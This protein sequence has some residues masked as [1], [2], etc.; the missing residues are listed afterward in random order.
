L[1]AKGYFD[2]Y[3]KLPGDGQCANCGAGTTYRNLSTGY[4]KCCSAKCSGLLPENRN[5]SSKRMVGKKQS[6]ETIAKRISNTDQIQKF[7]SLQ[8]TLQLRYGVSS[9]SQIDEAKT[10][11]SISNTGKLRPRSKEHQQKIIDTKRRNGTLSHKEGTKIKIKEALL[12]LY[13]SANILFVT[14]SEN[15]GGRH[16]NGYFNGV[17]YRSS[18]EL[19]FLRYCHLKN[20]EIVSAETT[21]FRVRYEVD[22]KK[23]WYYPDF[24][25][26]E[27]DIIIEIKPASLLLDE[28]VQAKIDAASLVHENYTLLTE[29]DLLDLGEVFRNFEYL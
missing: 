5:K 12:A 3:L 23:H 6:A 17:F 18:Y 22:H 16:K 2:L 10:K 15:S 26:P 4:L 29:E 8:K 19:C 24:Y 13:Q 21:E 20:I 14:A 25:L 9:P 11:I 1:T 27:Y 28:R 7:K